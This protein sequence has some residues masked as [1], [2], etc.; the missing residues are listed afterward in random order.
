MC[1]D[2]PVR[3]EAMLDGCELIRCDLSVS[4]CRAVMVLQ[5][6]EAQRVSTVAGQER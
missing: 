2:P 1:Y 3:V 5:Q 4:E 6:C